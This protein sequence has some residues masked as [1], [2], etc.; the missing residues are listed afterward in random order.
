MPVG[1]NDGVVGRSQGGSQ[2][3][4]NLAPLAK[5]LPTSSKAPGGKEVHARRPGDPGETLKDAIKAPIKN[6]VKLAPKLK[7]VLVSGA[8]K[9]VGRSGEGVIPKGP[10][11]A[12]HPE[13]AGLSS[14]SSTPKE[15]LK[16][17]LSEVAYYRGR[18][19]E[20]AAKIFGTD[21]QFNSSKNWIELNNQAEELLEK[22]NIPLENPMVKIFF[23]KFR[24]AGIRGKGHISP[25]DLFE[26]LS[27]LDMG[28]LLAT[29]V[30]K[31]FSKRIE[32]SDQ[33][34][35]R[36]LKIAEKL[37][38]PDNRFKSSCDWV[39][40][41]SQLIQLL[42][43]K[44]VPWNSQALREVLDGL[45]SC[46]LKGD[47]LVSKQDLSSLLFQL[48]RAYSEAKIEA[49]N[50]L[51]S[52][53]IEDTSGIESTIAGESELESLSKQVS[54][55]AIDL[56]GTSDI[57]EY[58][59]LIE[60]EALLRPHVEHLP[61]KARY[62]ID[63]Q[64][65]GYKN[66]GSTLDRLRALNEVLTLSNKL[67]KEHSYDSIA[68]TNFDLKI[69]PTPAGEGGMGVVFKAKLDGQPKF[70]KEFRG[71]SF[72][73][74]L[75]KANPDDPKL[76]RG[77]ELAAAYLKADEAAAICTP[78]HF[79]VR[80]KRSGAADTTYLV[81]TQNKQF[82]SW[83]KHK[84]M[85]NESDPA[86]TLEIT[87]SLQDVAKGQEL[88]EFITSKTRPDDS[89]LHAAAIFKSYT[90]ALNLL[91]ERGF[92]HGDLKLTNAFY[93]PV[94]QSISLIDT[95]SLTKISKDKVRQAGTEF[96]RDTRG[97]TLEYSA[98]KVIDGQKA[99]FEQ[100]AF[101]VGLQLLDVIASW[102]IPGVG[103]LDY[104]S[105]RE[106]INNLQMDV[107]N[108][109][110]SAKDAASSIRTAIKR[111]LPASDKP[112]HPMHRFEK[113]VSSMLLLGLHPTKLEPGNLAE[114]YRGVLSKISASMSA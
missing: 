23:N 58:V 89:F 57:H 113:A 10:L 91:S 53:L 63:Q 55:A 77:E 33:I 43:E 110:I 50:A 29:R 87:G 101:A 104:A 96:S 98:P 81:E 32:E 86:Y 15:P 82:R 1:K 28:L 45:Q 64:L 107:N 67:V 34:Q 103:V 74:E 90:D 92:V 13:V 84:L 42:K 114:S 111:Y 3:D 76:I 11:K 2:P 30:A 70:F 46:G 48:D 102:K 65:S 68:K 20:L 22:K 73:V 85:S 106:H 71:A 27:H 60:L 26:L 79:M 99:G 61:I 38:G 17:E 37:F 69:E 14:E 16:A 25:Q 24:E 35:A 97:I 112:T 56:T 54:K 31:A 51:P 21:N 9:V 39:D 88:Y 52:Y 93:D 18:S 49:E 5:D 8:Q 47:G 83:A 100:D 41:R 59:S 108:R 6:P 40:L 19:A 72:P 105:L 62:S 109:S 94:T 78:S 80:E 12:E 4:P 44:N 7:P 75:D 95:G 66:E 36:S